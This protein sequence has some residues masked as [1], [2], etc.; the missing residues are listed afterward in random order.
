MTAKEFIPNVKTWVDK[1]Q[2]C[3]WSQ[4][5]TW[6]KQAHQLCS[7][8]S[9]E[10]QTP[11]ENVVGILAALS[12][13]VSWNVNITSC[14]S[15]VKTGVIDPGYTGYKTNVEKA[16]QCLVS[17]PI[18]VLGGKKVLAFYH[19][20]LNPKTS[21]DVTIDTHIGRVLYDKMEL[22]DKETR[23]IFSKKGNEEAQEAIRK[24]SKS[25]RV[26]PHVL[27]ASLWVCVREIAQARA[28]KN[29]L[30]LYIK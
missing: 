12:P 26:I 3:H 27:Q 1:L 28:D 13:Q 6:Y 14:E 5:K 15:I 22:T 21:Q 19:N 16:L 30:S 24:V 4:G 29:Q 20:I 25:V 10:T 8:L 11:L 18:E 2:P 7:V 17:P 23:Y 9:E